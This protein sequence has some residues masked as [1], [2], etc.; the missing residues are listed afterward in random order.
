[1]YIQ[2]KHIHK[3]IHTVID[4]YLAP[5]FHFKNIYTLNITYTD[6]LESTGIQMLSDTERWMPPRDHP[7]CDTGN[8]EPIT[9]S[10]ECQTDISFVQMEYME[11]CV[12]DKDS[13][14]REVFVEKVTSS[15]SSVRQYTG[16]PSI[17]LL[18]G[19]FNIIYSK[20]LN[21]KY[22]NGPK[23]ANE[24]NYQQGSK[25]KPGP[26][27]KLTL[28]HEFILTLVRFRL[29]LVGFLLSD[30]FG[31]SNSRVSQIFVTWITFLATCFGKL[32]KWPSKMQVKKYMP[33]SFRNTYPKTRVII[34]C[35]EFFFQRPRSPSAQ[36]ETYST[37]KSKNTGKCLLGI[38]PSGTF[39]FVSDVY[40]GNVSDRYITEHSNF[41]ELIEEG[42][43]VM[44]DRGFTIRD[45]LTK[46]KATL[47]IPPFTRKCTWGK[48]KRLNVNEIKQTRNIAKLRIH[49]ERAIQ[50]LKLFKLL[51][52]NIPW[53]LKPVVNQ[54]VKVGV[55]LCN[56]MPKLVRK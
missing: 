10:T 47:N 36:S 17:A 50:R 27:R 40:G 30:I 21:L 38:S 29:G 12:N 15:D 22:W 13:F 23:S 16:I 33:K 43:D 18:F 44:A 2:T 11:R 8:N 9:I 53:H 7:Y 35:T 14:F 54:M 26:S 46:R 4:K 19:L 42:D 28:F 25:N 56:L 20:C 41:L 24:K 37:Y 49:V 52:N 1:M 6:S 31:I 5:L 55:F 34:D 39:T 45:L 51:G 48:K 3:C 32:I